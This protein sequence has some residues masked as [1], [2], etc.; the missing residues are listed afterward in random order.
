MTTD[1]FSDNDLK[2]A[3][4]FC[5]FIVLSLRSC[6]DGQS[7]RDALHEIFLNKAKAR[8]DS[9]K[10]LNSRK[11][12]NYLGGEPSITHPQYLLKSKVSQLSNVP[13]RF[14]GTNLGGIL[15]NTM[16]K[17]KANVGKYYPDSS[18]DTTLINLTS[19]SSGINCGIIK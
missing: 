11:F 18:V 1:R 7:S 15:G 12:S 5:L 10:K 13:V 19:F 17:V 16:G 9:V 8:E 6:L 14:L 2:G 3:V 4:L